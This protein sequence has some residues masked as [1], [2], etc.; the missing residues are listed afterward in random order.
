MAKELTKPTLTKAQAMS[1][2]DRIRKGLDDVS[3]L[4]Y[5]LHEGQ[6]WTALGYM[7]WK[8]CVAMEFHH[9]EW[10][11]KNQLRIAEVRK[12]LPPPPQAPERGKGQGGAPPHLSPQSG[13]ALSELAKVPEAGR[14]AVLA[15]AAEHSDGK[16]PTAKDIRRAAK[17]PKP[18]PAGDRPA[19]RE[20]GDEQSDADV[21]RV[22]VNIWA[23]AVGRW[24]G[25]SPSIDE[26]RHRW[27]GPKGDAVVK[28]ATTLYE[29]LKNW[30]KEIK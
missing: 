9:S 27:P 20:P 26:Y 2:C 25:Q 15:R 18:K 24:L 30:R 19:P 12:A 29:A 22:Q 11:G 13:R 7:T 14:P 3:Q 16:P 6:G 1:L 5:D 17:P 10:W 21:A 4:I 8:E 23:D 28:A